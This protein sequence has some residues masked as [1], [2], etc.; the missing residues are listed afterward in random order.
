MQ[1]SRFCAFSQHPRLVAGRPH[2]MHSARSC[3]Y[4]QHKCAHCG[5][6]GH[7]AADCRS[8]GEPPC[9]SSVD[10]APH[11]PSFPPPPPAPAETS[12]SSPKRL[13]VLAPPVMRKYEGTSA[14]SGAQVVPKQPSVEPSSSSAV[15]VHVC[16]KRGQ[17]QCN[18]SNQ[19]RRH[20]LELWCCSSC[21]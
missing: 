4:G 11:P 1:H 17:Q 7:G 18:H 20:L 3:P 6:A 19:R 5:K 13:R 15:P 16:K 9:C 14:K 8:S 21:A 12:Q 2:C 10:L